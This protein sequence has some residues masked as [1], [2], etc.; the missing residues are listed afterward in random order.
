M[1]LKFLISSWFLLETLQFI[2][3]FLYMQSPKLDSILQLRPHQHHMVQN[4]YFPCLTH[5]TPVKESRKKGALFAIAC[6]LW[7]IFHLW[8]PKTPDSLLPSNYF[9]LL[10]LCIYYIFS[11]GS[12]FE[13]YWISPGWFSY[14]S[15]WTDSFLQS[16]ANLPNLTHCPCKKRKCIFSLAFLTMD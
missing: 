15:F 12:N 5:D 3:I 8:S 9:H 14:R 10:S 16:A 11:K 6:P 4:N 13:F 7:V 2:Y 1:L